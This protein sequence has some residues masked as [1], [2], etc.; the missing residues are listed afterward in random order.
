MPEVPE[1]WR[2]EPGQRAQ[3]P[4]QVRRVSLESGFSE[5]SS[6]WYPELN[7][8][9]NWR[10]LRISSKSAPVGGS[11]NSLFKISIKSHRTRMAI[12]ADE[13]LA[14]IHVQEQLHDHLEKQGVQSEFVN[15]LRQ[16]LDGLDAGFFREFRI[17]FSSEGLFTWT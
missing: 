8:S 1:S 4:L 14:M 11:F 17:F 9:F 15:N 6:L 7:I 10:S 3:A 13:Q 2:H 12:I 5:Q 16:T